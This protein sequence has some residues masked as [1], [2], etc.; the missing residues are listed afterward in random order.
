MSGKM[1]KW[2]AAVPID[3]IIPFLRAAEAKVDTIQAGAKVL[4]FGHVGDGNLHMSV[5]PQG[6]KEGSRPSGLVP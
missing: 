4:A 3:R 2:D 5:W 1:L 6:S